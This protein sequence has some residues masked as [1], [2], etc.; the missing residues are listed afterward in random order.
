[1]TAYLS[2]TIQ[3]RRQ[4]RDIILLKEKKLS[5]RILQ[6]EKKKNLTKRKINKAFFRKI[7]VEFIPST[8]TAKT[9]KQLK[10]CL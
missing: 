8:C 9:N 5:P 2:K 10:T 1:M 7:K 6:P 3:T 4:W